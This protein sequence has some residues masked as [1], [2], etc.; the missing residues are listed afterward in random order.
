MPYKK[1]KC[2]RCKKAKPIKTGFKPH[3]Q[4]LDGHCHIC[5]TCHSKALLKGNGYKQKQAV[6]TSKMCNEDCIV[7][8]IDN[9]IKL[10]QNKKAKY[11][12]SKTIPA[13]FIRKIIE[14]L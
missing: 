14:Q 11:L 2:E 13:T 10:L 12:R 6:R 9:Q 7:L 1:K 5:K 3:N 8:E 4:T